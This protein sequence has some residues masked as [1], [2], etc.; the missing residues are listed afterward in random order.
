M[1]SS[2]PVHLADTNSLPPVNFALLA[3][4]SAS[5]ADL[6]A[7]ADD[8]GMTSTA[9]TQAR[10]ASDLRR[11]GGVAGDSMRTIFQIGQTN[12]NRE[13]GLDRLF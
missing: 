8:D 2:H 5:I 13:F 1:S 7:D 3:P 11:V 6:I 4:L 12:E 10:L 9:N